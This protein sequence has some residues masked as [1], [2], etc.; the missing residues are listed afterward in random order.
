MRLYEDDSE[1]I[2]DVYL[3][4]GQLG[5]SCR[6]KLKSIMHVRNAYSTIMTNN[7][8]QTMRFLTIV[9]V[10]LTIPTIVASLFGMNVPIPLGTNPYAFTGIVLFAILIPLILLIAVTKSR[11]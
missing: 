4:N 2:E 7:L 6:S 3:S 10:V 11:F 1:L 5:E 9:T 8:N